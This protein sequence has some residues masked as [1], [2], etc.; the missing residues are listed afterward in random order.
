MDITA[1]EYVNLGNKDDE[2]EVLNSE[3]KNVTQH[4]SYSLSF[5]KKWEFGGNINVGASFFNAI[6]AGGSSIGLGGTIKR[7]KNAF[8]DSTQEEERSLSQQYSLTGTITVPP[9]SK[10]TVTISTYAVNYKVNLNAVFTSPV[11]NVIPFF[12]KSG[13]GKLCCPGFGPTCRKWGFI[14]AQELFEGEKGFT[15]EGSTVT[16][17]R[18]AD[19]SYL[20][21]TIEM[22]KETQYAE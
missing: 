20:A 9:K 17:S 14:F 2:V 4:K 19:L 11:S 3:E 16:F 21:E 22:F 7:T 5:E 13:L 1:K 15:F 10:L 8:K 18:E 6:G 12:Y